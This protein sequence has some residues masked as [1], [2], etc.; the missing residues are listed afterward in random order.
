MLFKLKHIPNLLIRVFTK[1][2]FYICE[3]CHKIHKRDGNEVR[4]DEPRE[5]L[6]SHPLWYGSVGWDCFVY[7]Q[8]RV[9]K[10]LR[11]S[12]LERWKGEE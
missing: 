5:H 6:M 3:E 12:L 9:R 2:K 7:Q 1:D 8:R 11:E 4:L 10:I